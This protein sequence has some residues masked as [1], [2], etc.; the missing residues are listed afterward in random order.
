[1]STPAS[2]LTRRI[3]LLLAVAVLLLAWVVGQAVGDTIRLRPRAPVSVGSDGGAVALGDLATLEGT[4]AEGMAAVEIP[5]KASASAVT[6][7]DVRHA[8]TRANVNWA[9]VSLKGH[10][11]CVLSANYAGSTGPVR[12]PQ[13]APAAPSREPMSP[14]GA[15]GT[16]AAVVLAPVDADTPTTVRGLIESVLRDAM[17]DKADGLRFTFEPKH[18]ELLNAS[19][20][21]TGFEIETIGQPRLG[22]MNLR[23]HR[24]AG[25]GEPE[26]RLISVHVA[27][28]TRVV[29]STSHVQRHERLTKRNIALRDAVIDRPGL[30]HVFDLDDAQGAVCSSPIAAGQPV[31]TE[32]L[33]LPVLV[34]RGQRVS[35]E[36]LHRGFRM[37]AVGFAETDAA[38]GEPV[39]VRLDARRSRDTPVVTGVV[40]GIGRVAVD[41]AGA[42]SP[43]PAVASSR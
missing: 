23:V 42:A 8:L 6:L 12:A 13:A 4:Y 33:G 28:H 43:G 27:W 32:H 15:D 2:T 3:V 25:F 31:L 14:V 7:D 22:R 17:P 37:D 20:L 36:V 18:G 39:E 9:L 19:T 10:A 16:V 30:T 26:S 1:M 38:L 24:T 5:V 29:V 34:K 40:T 11:T 21:G 35:L 41:A